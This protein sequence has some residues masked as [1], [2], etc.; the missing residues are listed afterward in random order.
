MGLWKPGLSIWHL[1]CGWKWGLLG[2]PAVEA[3]VV[4]PPHT[5]ALYHS[6]SCLGAPAIK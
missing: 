1:L 6:S 5:E 4:N 2:E 3:A